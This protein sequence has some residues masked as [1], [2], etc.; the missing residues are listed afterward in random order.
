MN[1]IDTVTDFFNYIY[2]AVRGNTPQFLI[3]NWEDE[4]RVAMM[5]PTGELSDT[6]LATETMYRERRKTLAAKYKEVVTILSMAPAENH[7]AILSEMALNLPDLLDKL[8]IEGE[9][10]A[11]VMAEFQLMGETMNG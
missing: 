4:V 1:I 2:D 6:V 5:D 3:H 9:L 10:K 11:S 7:M 8:G